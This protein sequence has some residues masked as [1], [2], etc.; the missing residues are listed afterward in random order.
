MIASWKIEKMTT[1]Y[2]SLFL[3]LE[4]SMTGVFC[5]QDLF[6][7]YVFWELMLLPMYFLIGI[8]GSPSRVY[9]DGPVRGGPYAAIKFFLYTLVGSVLM[10][11][12]I[13]YLWKSTGTF[14]MLV[15]SEIGLSGDAPWAG[16]T[17]FGTRASTVLYLLFFL[18]FAIKVPVFPF[19]TWLPDA[20]VEAPTAVSVILAGVLLKL[21]TYGILRINYPFFPDAT[22][23]LAYTVAVFG[24]INI[25]YGAF[26]AM[27]QRDLKRLVAYSSISHMGYV[28]LGMSA[29]TTIDGKANGPGILGGVLQMW[30][31]GT[32][33]AMLFLLVGVIYE[34]LHHRDIDRMGGDPKIDLLALF[35][36]FFASLG[37]PALGLSARPVLSTWADPTYDR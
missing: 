17:L 26:C 20:H 9:P 35:V 18:S 3:L 16:D 37:L 24:V 22:V 31:H 7:F 5:S 36:A 8:L 10:L 21:G 33:T 23:S 34:R 13:V 11:I 15:I 4:S 32:I 25:L 30:N 19:H 2:L 14:D 27:A 29:L 12:G 6:L 1:G 28:L